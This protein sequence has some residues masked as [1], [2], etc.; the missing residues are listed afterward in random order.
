MLM[1]CKVERI[2]AERS[3]KSA[4]SG[5]KK[6][7]KFY[8]IKWV[9]CVQRESCEMTIKNVIIISY[10][11]MMSNLHHFFCFLS[12]CSLDILTMRI[13]GSQSNTFLIK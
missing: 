5:S 7:S 11:T 6:S 3:V 13:L 12:Y 2:V 10:D 9:R 4:K 1:P 8:F